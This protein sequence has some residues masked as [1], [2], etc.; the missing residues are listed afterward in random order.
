MFRPDPERQPAAVRRPLARNLVAMLG[1]LALVLGFLTVAATTSQDSAEAASG[2]DFNA[3]NIISDAEF[4]NAGT[5]SAGDIQAFLNAKVPNCKPGYVCLKDYSQA[6]ATQG[7][8]SEGCST[9]QGSA[10]ESAATIIY[11]VAAACGINPQVILVL[12]EKEQALIT[13]NW[14]SSRQYRSATGYGCPDTADCDANYFGFHNQ[15]YNAA[16]QFKKYQANPGSRGYVAGRWNTIQWNP[17]GACGSSN[18]YIENQATA[19]LY[20]Y[21]PYRPNQAA[22]DNMGRTGDGCSSYGNRNFWAWYT[23][24][25]GDT[26]GGSSIVRDTSTGGLFLIAGTSKYP[27]PTM[28]VYYALANLGG[29]R[30]VPASYLAGY[31]SGNV[32]SELVRNP[33]TGEIA[34]VQANSRHRFSTCSQVADWGYDCAKAIDLMPGQW[35]KL[36]ASGD[37]SAFVVQPGS[38]TVYYLNDSTRFPVDEWAGV[39]RLNGGAAPWVGTIR[40]GAAERFPVGRLLVTPASAVMSAS[41]SDVFL[42][43]GWGSRIRVPSMAILAEYGLKSIRTVSDG[44]LGGYPRTGSD[45]TVVAKCNGT[46]G[47]VNG[48]TFSPLASNGT[49]IP[50]TPL[51][52]ST[53]AAL[54]GGATIAGPVFVLT[55]GSPDVYL[56]S[57][58]NARPVLGW[59]DVVRLNNG[60]APVIA[61]LQGGTVQALP[62]PG[63]V[64]APYSLV[65]TNQDATVWVTDG[66]NKKLRLDSFGTSD[67][68]GLGSW[69]VA[70][71]HLVNV[72]GDAG[73]LSRVVLCSG[74]TYIGL[75]GTLYPVSAANP[76]GL[77][78]ATLSAAC[79]GLNRSGAAPLDR[80]FLKSTDSAVVYHLLNGQRRAVRSWSDLLGLNGGS[81][82][83]IFTVKPSEVSTLPDGG[84]M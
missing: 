22:L 42:I 45:L 56:L 74:T 35:S 62:H 61:T 39:L 44:A 51:D 4:Y 82:P 32:A 57:D 7:A 30:D 73:T 58:G 69:R 65:K 49:G 12:L 27:V 83:Q 29:Y 50:V 67:A 15:V 41:S 3:G 71:D 24:W 13:D 1:V 18:V 16:Y 31:T 76:H 21:T 47:L 2:S 40:P 68:L 77:P 20:V 78:V 52:A 70:P 26:H 72:Y 34:L 84:A 81:E 38:S 23:D 43:D 54:R 17:N 14:P 80:V 28:D 33:L 75:G 60:S 5:M 64:A 6:T 48:G 55:P 59:S 25:F 11:K 10:N 63:G 46:D 79:G 37:V 66:L 19:G 9:Y 36:P 53:C 8:K